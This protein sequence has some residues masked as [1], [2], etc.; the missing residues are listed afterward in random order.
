[1]GELTG[2]TVPARI[3][4]DVMQVATEPYGNA[5]FEYPE[6]ILN[7]FKAPGVSIIPQSEAKKEF[8][9][10]EKKARELEEQQK[11][12]PP[13]APII[14]PDS[15]K[16]N[17]IIQMPSIIKK[18]EIPTIEVQ[19]ERAAEN[20]GGNEEVQYAPVPVTAAPVGQ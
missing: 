19:Q 9:E 6:V 3:W 1:M 12:N 18:K 11:N 7:P 13:E 15:I 8:E 17:N 20:T 16:P 14:K 4:K 5:D 10:Q 2:G